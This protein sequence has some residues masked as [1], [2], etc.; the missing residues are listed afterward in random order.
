MLRYSRLCAYYENASAEP[1][2]YHLHETPSYYIKNEFKYTGY[3]CYYTRRQ[4][5]DSIFSW[6]SETTNIWTQ[7]LGILVFIYVLY[8]KEP[9]N[10]YQRVSDLL[11]SVLHSSLVLLAM[12]ISFF[13]HVLRGHHCPR[14]IKTL[15]S[16]DNA[17]V[18][19]A[20]LSIFWAILYYILWD[21]QRSVRILTFSTLFAILLFCILPWTIYFRQEKYRWASSSFRVSLL[22]IAL[23]SVEVSISRFIGHMEAITSLHYYSHYFALATVFVGGLTYHYRFPERFFPGRL[24]LS[25]AGHSLWHLFILAGVILEYDFLNTLKIFRLS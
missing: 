8:R 1:A 21:D 25:L 14:V 23:V 2:L 7:I 13:Y 19:V 12:S 24:D 10:L 11:I 15:R 9:F 6:H 18:G 16:M 3:R 4:L 17:S 22:L 5:F 20:G